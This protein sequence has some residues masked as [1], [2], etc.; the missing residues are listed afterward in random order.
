MYGEIL[1]MSNK[2]K[3]HQKNATALTTVFP[4]NG[5]MFVARRRMKITV[6]YTPTVSIPADS[7]LHMRVA[8]SAVSVVS[9]SPVISTDRSSAT[10]EFDLYS[11]NSYLP[12]GDLSF[13]V[14]CYSTAKDAPTI[15]V[16]ETN[17]T[18]KYTLTTPALDQIEKILPLVVKPYEVLDKN[19]ATD[20][21]KPE[22]I[23]SGVVMRLIG[24]KT[25]GTTMDNNGIYCLSLGDL[26]TSNS[27]RVFY[28]NPDDK[29]LGDEIFS[30]VSGFECYFRIPLGA[31]GTVY[32]KV[33]QRAN[34]LKNVF[35]ARPYITTLYGTSYSNEEAIFVNDI[36]VLPENLTAP[37][38]EELKG[39][40]ITTEDL[41]TGVHLKLS[42]WD[43]RSDD[44]Y[45]IPFIKDGKNNVSLSQFY[46]STI[47][48]IN[49]FK[50]MVPYTYFTSN[51]IY[52]LG[53][54]VSDGIQSSITSS[55]VF[56][57]VDNG[58]GVL[59]PDIERDLPAPS[60]RW[61]LADGKIYNVGRNEQEPTIFKK[62]LTDGELK[63]TFDISGIDI[64]VGDPLI[65]TGV[66]TGFDDK[67]LPRT[68][69]IK[70]G[71]FYVK[72]ENINDKQLTI[73]LDKTLFVGFDSDQ[74]GNA[75][76]VWLAG[77]LTNTILA[78]NHNSYVWY[79]DIDTVAPGE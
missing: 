77:T 64:N 68:F 52:T 43:D 33:F 67:L 42:N 34:S 50:I 25:D 4:A 35:R 28:Y 29:S 3:I 38:I 79:S 65:L 75:G 8:S 78:Q 12:S 55:I 56:K 66:I 31:D 47:D 51:N 46:K 7:T 5:A 72:Q 48:V 15:P 40:T 9:F 23:N 61:E 74:Y 58:G 63:M 17:S 37:F 21:K 18:I 2:A 14:H 26:D 27:L 59:P 73:T 1:I 62:M 76:L 20:D 22:A 41:K 19:P 24:L 16:E 44:G 11:Q 57:F 30:V 6:V 13:D 32:I 71:G 10:C 54:I 53:C 45:V 70:Q 60:V 39:F 49:H 36:D 69:K